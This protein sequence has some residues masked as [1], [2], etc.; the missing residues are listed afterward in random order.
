MENY[1]DVQQGARGP[2]SCPYG[3]ERQFGRMMILDKHIKKYHKERLNDWQVQEGRQG[4]MDRGP[5]EAELGDYKSAASQRRKSK[6]V[7]ARARQTS[8]YSAKK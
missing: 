6:I 2:Y 3:C 5:R 1:S 7:M 4:L 8:A